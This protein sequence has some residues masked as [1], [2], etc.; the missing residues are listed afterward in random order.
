MGGLAV[1]VLVI[2]ATLPVVVPFLLIRSPVLAARTAS[3]VALVLLFVIG[4][5]WAHLVNVS[6]IR[7]GAGLTLVG[8]VLALIA[9]ALGG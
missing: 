6:S 8:L 5:W 7:F 1:T 9:I 3:G 4:S 2:V